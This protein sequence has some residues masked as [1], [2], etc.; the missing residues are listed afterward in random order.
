M[1]PGYLLFFLMLAFPAV[2]SVLYIKA[3]LFGLVL[4]LVGVR[5]VS[6]LYLR[7]DLKV[8]AWTLALAVISLFFCFRGMFLSAPGAV[9]CVPVYVIW[10]L[11][12]LLLLDGL[13]SARAFRGLE[14]TL[15]FS[16]VFIGAFG[17]ACSLS[18]LNVLPE[19]PYREAVFSDEDLGVGSFDGYTRMAYPGFTSLPFLLPFLMALL[20]V[21][22]SRPGGRISKAWL[23]IG[24]V[25]N[26]AITLVSGRRALQLVTMVA[27]VL[28][29]AFL[30]F[31]PRAEALPLRRSL[32][33]TAVAFFLG[34]VL[35]V[36]L[37]GLTYSLEFQG[38]AERFSSG[39]D[40]GPTSLDD[41][42]GARREQYFALIQGW[43]RNPLIGAGLGA[44]A[45]GSIRSD[46]MP[47]SYELYYLALLF[48]TGIFGI[49]AYTAGIV[50]V[51]W[52]SIRIIKGGGIIGRLLI[53][54]LVGLS[55]FLFAAGTNPNLARFDGIWAI[56]L[57][58][59]FINYWLLE[60]NGRSHSSDGGRSRPPGNLVW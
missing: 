44:S 50:W 42:P 7:L 29:L 14:R 9:K 31:L 6:R 20:A 39:W 1:W 46:T 24:I 47:W 15:V 13:D 55:C 33:R 27:P 51:F 26:L 21:R 40:F 52:S 2:L 58:L 53:P 3:F 30:S 59:A 32:G 57:P 37:L 11:A 8:V 48:Q 45:Y 5:A 25:L 4:L 35:L 18:V 12:Y 43:S 36:S 56:F 19:I 23:C 10:P 22:W 34:V 41:S 17:L 28:T 16:S 60:Q 54:V 49:A 38:L